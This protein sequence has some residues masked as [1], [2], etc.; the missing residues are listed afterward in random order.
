M[1]QI[2]K[3]GKAPKILEN[4]KAERKRLCDEFLAN[5][6]DYEIG[7]KKFGKF[8]SEIYGHEDVR[9]ILKILQNGKC[10]L[11]ESRIRHISYENVEHFRPKGGVQQGEK[12][13]LSPI[14]YFWLAYEW[15]NLFLSCP[16]CNISYKRN[17]FPLENPNDRATTDDLGDLSKEK[18]LFI[19]PETENPE[20][21]ITFRG[22]FPLALDS[23]GE[24]TIKYAGLRRKELRESRLELYGKLKSLYEVVATHPNYPPAKKR[25][26]VKKLQKELKK[27]V[28]EK[29]QYVSMFKSAIRDKFRY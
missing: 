12:D 4:G 29:H 14:G 2:K 25:R 19:N 5:K 3:R 28:S 10:F 18:P 9:E 17:F 1:I 6:A 23:K 8:N 16:V 20:L 22:V 11:C 7:L 24:T 27:C 15:S 21:S 26:A 13:K